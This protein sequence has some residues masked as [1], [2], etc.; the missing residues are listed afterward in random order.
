MVAR[1][2]EGASRRA[3]QRRGSGRRSVQRGGVSTLMGRKKPDGGPASAA[4]ESSERRHAAEA[5]VIHAATFALPLLRCC[6]AGGV[7]SSVLRHATGSAG[8]PTWAHTRR[9]GSW[10][11]QG[12]PLRFH[13]DTIGAETS[14]CAS[15]AIMSRIRAEEPAARASSE[16]KLETVCIATTLTHSERTGK[17]RHLPTGNGPEHRSV[18]QSV[19]GIC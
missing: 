18:S 3:A 12:M 10:I 14:I 8:T 19:Y 5:C 11:F 4:R 16:M 6:L 1:R 17:D 7:R 15:A 2:L 13:M 9:I